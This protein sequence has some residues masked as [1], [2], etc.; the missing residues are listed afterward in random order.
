MLIGR[1]TQQRCIGRIASYVNDLMDQLNSRLCGQDQWEV[2][3][4][5]KTN[6]TLNA[7]IFNPPKLQQHPEF[8][9]QGR[10]VFL[11]SRWRRSSP[12]A[13]Q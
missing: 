7:N 12:P 6:Y 8:R 1:E 13:C 3:K 5:Q 10:I 4:I 2:E 9:N 11:G